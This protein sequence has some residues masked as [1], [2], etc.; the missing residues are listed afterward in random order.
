MDI[1]VLHLIS[2]PVD[3]PVTHEQ[4]GALFASFGEVFGHT[5]NE[6]RYA[7]TR[8]ALGLPADEVVSWSAHKPGAL[9]K[10]EASKV[11]DTLNL[12]NV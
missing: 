1:I 11:L 6:Q 2:I 12:L 8:L 7:F 4:R 3:E 10:T 5:D 9:S